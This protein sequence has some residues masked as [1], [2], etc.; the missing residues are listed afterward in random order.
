MLLDHRTI[1]V[2]PHLHHLCCM[3]EMRKRKCGNTIYAN[4]FG[5]NHYRIVEDHCLEHHRGGRSLS[6]NTWCPR[7]SCQNECKYHVHLRS[8]GTNLRGGRPRNGETRGCKI[9]ACQS[10]W[11]GRLNMLCSSHNR[12][13]KIKALAKVWTECC[14]LDVLWC[15]LLTMR[16]FIPG[17]MLCVL[18]W[19]RLNQRPSLLLFWSPLFP[20][21]PRNLAT[22]QKFFQFRYLSI[23]SKI[24]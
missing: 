10:F 17:I 21:I 18:C 14:R 19:G 8:R 12:A 5:N 4:F 13:M 16:S 1:S 7:S 9:R 11:V 15:G 20:L 6:K 3:T 2:P 22:A 23:R 24:W